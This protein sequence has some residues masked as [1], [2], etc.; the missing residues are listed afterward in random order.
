MAI[1]EL[2]ERKAFGYPPYSHLTRILIRHTDYNTLHRAA[3]ALADILRK[4]FGTRIMGPVSSSLEMLR[5]EHR[6]EILLKIEAGA[7]MQRARTLL[8]QA[9][10]NYD[11]K[12]E[13]K[14]IK[15]DVDVDCW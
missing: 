15:I 4:K 3:H 14:G 1:N 7:S 13:Y 8:R 10:D 11:S 6:A 9:L 5:G 2:N 12:K